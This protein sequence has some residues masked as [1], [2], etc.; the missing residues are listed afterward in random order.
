M[1]KEKFLSAYM[2]VIL[3][4]AT[5][6]L[7]VGVILVIS[8]IYQIDY[9]TEND[10][11]NWAAV[12]IEVGIAGFIS[13]VV[14]L[15]DKKYKKQMKSQQGEISEL[16]IEI[17]NME[18][19][20]LDLDKKLLE[21]IEQQSLF[22]N[23]RKNFAYRKIILELFN[24]LNG[25]KQIRQA[26]PEGGEQYIY[27]EHDQDSYVSY[28]NYPIEEPIQSIEHVIEL[29]NDVID[30]DTLYSLFAFIQITKTHRVSIYENII[31]RESINFLI[32]PLEKL[33]EKIT[34]ELENFR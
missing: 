24:V 8:G 19:S 16:V 9:K 6:M 7:I 29:S 33:I 26:I 14:L 32:P 12:V 30:S 27:P 4:V 25:I 5:S 13:G 18:K 22:T 10:F 2:F 15:F 34:I 23:N 20:Q 28:L 21:T 17:Q 1:S 3:V 11:M 31:S